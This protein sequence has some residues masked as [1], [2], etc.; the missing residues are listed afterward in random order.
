MPFKLTQQL[1]LQDETISEDLCPYGCIERDAAAT[2]G[3]QPFR[4]D[5]ELC[6]DCGACAMGCPGKFEYD[7]PFTRYEPMRIETVHGPLVG[8]IGGWDGNEEVAITSRKHLPA[9]AM[10]PAASRASGRKPVSRTAKKP[11]Q[12]TRLTAR[13]AH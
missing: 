8:S 12:R 13:T 4:I 6:T 9:R 11:V 3:G 7:R 10:K 5:A 1:L 2:N